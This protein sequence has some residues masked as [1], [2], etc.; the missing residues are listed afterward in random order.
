MAA[1]HKNLPF[2]E[3]NQATRLEIISQIQDKLAITRE[4]GIRRQITVVTQKSDIAVTA[5]HHKYPATG[6]LCHATAHISTSQLV[7]T[8]EACNDTIIITSIRVVTN[9][10]N[11]VV[12]TIITCPGNEQFTIGLLHHTLSLI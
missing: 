11:V 10:N 12:N 8:T 6:Q 1:R 5:S 9:K 7:V 3:H 4:R 2:R